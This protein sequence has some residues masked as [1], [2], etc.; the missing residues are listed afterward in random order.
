MGG[1]WPSGWSLTFGGRVVGH[2]LW[3]PSGWSLSLAAE[4]WV[5][6]LAAEWL[7]TFLGGRVVGHFLWRPGGLNDDGFNTSIVRS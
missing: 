1:R 5:T 7:V 3:R 4:W 2:F 6:F